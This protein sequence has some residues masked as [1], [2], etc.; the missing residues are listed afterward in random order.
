LKQYI[1][2]EQLQYASGVF[3]GLCEVVLAIFLTNLL[4]HSHFVF[5]TPDMNTN[6]TLI[7][8]A[9]VIGITATEYFI[10][11]YLPSYFILKKWRRANASKQ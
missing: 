8:C 10:T 11:L 3:I 5:F 6:Q 7:F 4:I 2:K 1:T 9:C